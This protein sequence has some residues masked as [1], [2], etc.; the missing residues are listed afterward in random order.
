LGAFLVYGD[1]FLQY[2]YSSTAYTIRLIPTVVRSV[3]V[4]RN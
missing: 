1:T 4:A 3:V 2:Y